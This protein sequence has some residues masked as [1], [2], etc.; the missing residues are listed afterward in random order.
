VI[1]LA[2]KS[3]HNFFFAEK[4]SSFRG[5]VSLKSI[6]LFKEASNIQEKDQDHFVKKASN[7]R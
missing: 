1:I 3:L 7:F 5:I 2:A 4:A 6:T